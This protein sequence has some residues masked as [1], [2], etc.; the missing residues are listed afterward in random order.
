METNNINTKQ[1]LTLQ[2]V[3]NYTGLSMS[4]LYK[5]THNSE[6]PFYKPNGKKI[7]IDRLELETWLKRNRIK[8][9]E[10]IENEVS[11]NLAF[12]K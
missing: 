12:K 1:V 7:F 9:R 6:L 5:L 11:S 2:E 8:S 4:Y 10:E 3:S